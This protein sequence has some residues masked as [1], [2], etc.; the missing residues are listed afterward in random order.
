MLAKVAAI[1]GLN[2]VVKEK[3]TE[4][5]ALKGRLDRLEKPITDQRH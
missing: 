1:P 5:H 2:E 3:V 4:I